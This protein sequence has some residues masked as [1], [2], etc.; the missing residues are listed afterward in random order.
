MVQRKILFLRLESVQLYMH[1][2]LYN[3]KRS[4]C[5]NLNFGSVDL[6]FHYV[7]C[8]NASISRYTLQICF[9]FKEVNSEKITS[10]NQY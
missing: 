5:K 10:P 4:F 3:G 1:A 9:V 7:S 8:V 6:A 2:A